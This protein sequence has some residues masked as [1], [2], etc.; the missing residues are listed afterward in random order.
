MHDASFFTLFLPEIQLAPW[1]LPEITW[2]GIPLSGFFFELPWKD[3]KMPMPCACLAASF[4]VSLFI[5]LFTANESR[6]MTLHAAQTTWLYHS[7]WFEKFQRLIQV[8][9]KTV[10][11][12]NITWIYSCSFYIWFGWYNTRI[13]PSFVENKL[14]LSV[15]LLCQLLF[16][17]DL[18]WKRARSRYF[19]AILVHKIEY[20][21]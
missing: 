7:L 6:T 2:E 8:K 4:I 9:L 3:G 16:T 11:Y 20:L 12:C 10:S 17:S 13:S 18:H 1:K 21:L 14:N 5:I 19:F 15:I